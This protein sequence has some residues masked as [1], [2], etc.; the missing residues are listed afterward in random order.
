MECQS[1]KMTKQEKV[2]QTF[3]KR[4]CEMVQE[5]NETERRGK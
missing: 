4:V 5:F 1:N 2:Y 3:V